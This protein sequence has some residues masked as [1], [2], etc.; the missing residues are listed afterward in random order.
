MLA[1]LFNPHLVWL[2]VAAASA[3]PMQWLVNFGGLGVVLVLVVTGFL[4]TKAEVAALTKINDERLEAMK[5]KDKA[6]DDLVSQLTHGVLPQLVRVTEV[7]N[8]LS[9]KIDEIERR[10]R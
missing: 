4:R 9:S 8:A 10:N 1:L 3:D 2:T 5:Q 7:L 6:L